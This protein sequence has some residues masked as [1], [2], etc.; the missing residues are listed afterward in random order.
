MAATQK[1]KIRAIKHIDFVIPLYYDQ[2]GGG[3]YFFHEHPE[4]WGT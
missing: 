1:A 3:R 2:L 4:Q